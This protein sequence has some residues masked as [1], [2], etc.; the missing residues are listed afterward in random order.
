MSWDVNRMPWCRYVT[1]HCLCFLY[2]SDKSTHTACFCGRSFSSEEGEG[3][4]TK[5]GACYVTRRG[6]A[7]VA[8]S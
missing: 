2:Q 8:S 3:K 5:K 7:F 4:D 6:F 1:D